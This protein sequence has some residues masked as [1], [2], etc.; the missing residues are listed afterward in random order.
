M[1]TFLCSWVQVEAAPGEWG[2]PSSPVAASMFETGGNAAEEEGA[3]WCPPLQAGRQQSRNWD[4]RNF[5][6][7]L[8]NHVTCMCGT[9]QIK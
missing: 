1:Y 3:C 5:M 9:W 7:H 6:P 2:A 8:Q 4:L